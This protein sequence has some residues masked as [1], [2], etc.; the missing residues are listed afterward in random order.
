M[1]STKIDRKHKLYGRWKNIKYRCSDHCVVEKDYKVYAGRGIT[2]CDEWKNDY[3]KFRDW[4]LENGYKD[5][6]DLDRV[7]PDKGYS[8][9][10]C[11]YVTHIENI[12]NNRNIVLSVEKAK[13]IAKKY[14]SGEYTYLELMKEYSCGHN[15]IWQIL[16]GK[17][18]CEI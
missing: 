7:N 4:S 2:L 1:A 16:R 10:N 3:S 14:K 8:P 18:W 12:R 13:E 9:S 6:L 11:R 17:L 15:Q 5:G